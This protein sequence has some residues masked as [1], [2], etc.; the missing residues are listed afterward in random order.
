MSEEDIIFFKG[1]LL[2]LLSFG[3]IKG[4]NMLLCG[5]KQFSL[6]FSLIPLSVLLDSLKTNFLTCAAFTVLFTLFANSWTEEFKTQLFCVSI[7]LGL[8]SF[9][10]E[11]E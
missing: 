6:S 5:L 4:M 10:V 9:S 8:T 2:F 11:S 3:K 7:E 1:E